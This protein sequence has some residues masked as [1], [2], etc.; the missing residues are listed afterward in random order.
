VDLQSCVFETKQ[1]SHLT[2]SFLPRIQW[3]LKYV[4]LKQ[5]FPL[6]WGQLFFESHITTSRCGKWDPD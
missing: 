2:K 6:S 1:T 4:R 3:T 5:D